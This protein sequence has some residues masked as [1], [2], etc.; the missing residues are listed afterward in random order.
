VLP[1]TALRRNGKVVE[2]VLPP[3]L[4]DLRGPRPETRLKQFAALGGLS[5]AL[6]IEG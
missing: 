3:E 6:V 4:A 2:L 5:S 1:R